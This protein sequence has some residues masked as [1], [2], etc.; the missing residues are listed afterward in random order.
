V[1]F[2]LLFFVSN[3]TKPLSD[4]SYILSRSLTLGLVMKQGVWND[5]IMLRKKQ[6]STKCD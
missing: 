5:T 3:P 2:G 1:L 4:A 6:N